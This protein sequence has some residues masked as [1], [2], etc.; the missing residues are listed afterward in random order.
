MQLH[1]ASN[2]IDEFTNNDYEYWYPVVEESAQIILIVIFDE[3]EMVVKD[4][5]KVGIGRSI[6]LIDDII[7]LII[8]FFATVVVKVLLDLTVLELEREVI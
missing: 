2:I 1:I 4:G 8:D 5:G 6:P 7:Q 3:E